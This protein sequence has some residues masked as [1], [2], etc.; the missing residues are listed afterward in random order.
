MFIV[1]KIDEYTREY[2]SFKRKKDLA[3]VG[4]ATDLRI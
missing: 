3:F 1:L 2:N 4:T